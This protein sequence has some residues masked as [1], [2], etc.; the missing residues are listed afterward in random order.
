MNNAKAEAK[1]PGAIPGATMPGYSAGPVGIE[2]IVVS[3]EQRKALLQRAAELRSF[4]RRCFGKLEEGRSAFVSHNP[5][6]RVRGLKNFMRSMDISTSSVEMDAAETFVKLMKVK[7]TVADGAPP[8]IEQ[9]QLQETIVARQQTGD[10]AF[11]NGLILGQVLFQVYAETVGESFA[12]TEQSN[13]KAFTNKLAVTLLDDL[14]S[15]KGT[16]LY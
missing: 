9:K 13:L 12:D 14:K 4:E 7:A 5:R 11:E 3:P 1:K 2:Q 8:S 16:F 15:A 10:R 6:E